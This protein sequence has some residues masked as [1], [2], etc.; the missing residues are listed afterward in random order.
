MEYLLECLDKT[1]G[2]AESVVMVEYHNPMVAQPENIDEP[3]E[4]EDE[5][6]QDKKVEDKKVPKIGNVE[7]NKD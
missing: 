4:D 2:G 7:N 3:E 5:T 6:E 1:P